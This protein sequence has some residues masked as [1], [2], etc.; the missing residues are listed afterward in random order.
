MA[1]ANPAVRK[2][3][4]VFNGIVFRRYPDSKRMEDRRYFKPSGMHVKRGVRALHREIWMAH[5]GPIP[6]GWHVHHKNGDTGDN[7]IENLACMPRSEHLAYHGK[8]PDRVELARSNIEIARIEAIKWHKSEAG[9]EWH[10]QHGR[11]VWAGLQPVRYTCEQCGAEF[12]TLAQ[13][14]AV[15][16]CSNNC[17]SAW[18]RAS[19]IDDVDR[20]CANCGAAFRVNRYSTK[21]TCSRACGTTLRWRKHRERDASA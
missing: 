10:K 18:R 1:K 5:H 11:D 20:E 19:G 21:Q 7:R 13:H 12:E 2:E 14:D 3:E 6:E 9:R 17:K 16:F 15:R 8:Q 4:V